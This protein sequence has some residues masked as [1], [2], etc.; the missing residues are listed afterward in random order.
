MKRKLLV[1]IVRI[2]RWAMLKL[3]KLECRLEKLES[4]TCS[5]IYYEVMKEQGLVPGQDES[6]PAADAHDCMTFKANGTC[7]GCMHED[8]C[9]YYSET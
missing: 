2:I 7:R 4:R 6:T 3:E 8:C 5:A 9:P 1:T